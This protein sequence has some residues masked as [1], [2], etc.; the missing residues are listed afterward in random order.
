MYDWRKMTAE[1]RDEVLKDR[2]QKGYPW[3]SPPHQ[4]GETDCYFISGAC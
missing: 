4:I 2:Q 3:H 1:E